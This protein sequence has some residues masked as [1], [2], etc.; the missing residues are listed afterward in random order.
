MS[1]VSVKTLSRGALLAWILATVVYN[2]PGDQAKLYHLF[3]RCGLPLPTWKFFAPV[4]ATTDLV[5]AYR[6]LTA[7]RDAQTPWKTVDMNR[8]RGRD[9][10]WPP[11]SRDRKAYSDLT[12]EMRR[13]HSE[14]DNDLTAIREL[15]VYAVMTRFVRGLPRL[16]TQADLREF[17]IV[18]AHTSID[19]PTVVPLF[20]SDAFE[21]PKAATESEL[22]RTESE[23]R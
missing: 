9:I 19:D 8:A 16:S 18:E 10:F 20:F 21:L 7:D 6:D 1:G 23:T 14:Y 17:M 5:L 3:R 12:Q 13:A 11:P 22:N 15:P 2:L 4:P